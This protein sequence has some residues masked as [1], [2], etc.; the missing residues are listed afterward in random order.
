MNL[1]RADGEFDW[2]GF[3]ALVMVGMTMLGGVY[4]L[5]IQPLK[6]EQIDIRQRVRTNS[7]DIRSLEIYRAEVGVHIEKLAQAVD[8]LADKI[9]D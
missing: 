4:G 2:G 8:K 5:A 3:A 9:E 1:R 6:D 7:N